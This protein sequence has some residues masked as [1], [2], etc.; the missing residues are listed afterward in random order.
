MKNINDLPAASEV[1]LRD[2]VQQLQKQNLALKR[3]IKELWWM[4]LIYADTRGT[5]VP[6]SY[7]KAIDL[8]LKNGV[9]F[10]DREIY[11]CEIYAKDEDF[12]KWIP[13]QQCFKGE[14]K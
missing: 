8:A 2:P 1:G 9:E 7:N 12:D 3:V 5:C 6:R 11:V 10:F 4:A 14:I 13:E